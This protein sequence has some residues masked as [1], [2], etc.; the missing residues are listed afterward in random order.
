MF[1]NDHPPAHVH[2]VY[3]GRH[4]TFRINP[5]GMLSGHLPGRAERMVSDWM[6]MHQHELGDNWN[7]AREHRQ[8]NHVEPLD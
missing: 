1:Y 6:A 4:A 8:L 3:A 7:R 5:V 2:A